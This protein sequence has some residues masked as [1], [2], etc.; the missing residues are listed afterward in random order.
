MYKGPTFSSYG[1]YKVQL[2][3]QE[4]KVVADLKAGCPQASDHQRQS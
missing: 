2:M 4:Q 1:L 3:S